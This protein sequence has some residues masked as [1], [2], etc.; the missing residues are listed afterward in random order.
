MDSRLKVIG[1]K[2]SGSEERWELIGRWAVQRKSGS[3]SDGGRFRGK[4]GAYRTVG[5]SEERWELRVRSDVR[6]DVDMQREERRKTR[7]EEQEQKL[8][9]FWSSW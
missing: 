2:V 1:L 8:V 9:C 7:R 5:G 6:K 3:L 4:V